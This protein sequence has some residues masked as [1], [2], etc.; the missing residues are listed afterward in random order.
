MEVSFSSISL[1][2]KKEEAEEKEAPSR[3]FPSG[4]GRGGGRDCF[5]SLSLKKGEEE[6]PS[7]PSPS[8]GWRASHSE[9]QSIVN[10]SVLQPWV[11]KTMC[12]TVF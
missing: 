12:F 4:R 6:V 7:F 5:L 10:H 1:W 8:E 11:L 3:P 2:K 9:V